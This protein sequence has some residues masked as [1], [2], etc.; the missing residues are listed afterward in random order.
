MS[1]LLCQDARVLNPSLIMESRST[2]S[3]HIKVVFG[4]PF[5]CMAFRQ[6]VAEN[7]FA[8]FQN[9]LVSTLE[10]YEE[11][12]YRLQDITYYIFISRSV[13]V[14]LR[15]SLKSQSESCITPKWVKTHQ[16]RRSIKTAILCL[17]RPERLIPHT[18]SFSSLFVCFSSDFFSSYHDEIDFLSTR[19]VS[20]SRCNILLG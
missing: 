8:M 3:G 18:Q 7:Y 1:C 4:D 14:T 5:L 20:I 15:S 6:I 16:S 17:P 2:C 12:V 19:R 10:S 9:G 11:V 13:Y